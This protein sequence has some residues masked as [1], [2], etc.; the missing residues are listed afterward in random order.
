M[1]I[2]Q[3]ALITIIIGVSFISINLLID[4]RELSGNFTSCEIRQI[5]IGMT[6]EQVQQTLGQPFQIT[7]LAGLHNSDCTRQKSR[8]IKDI[9]E[10]SDI[11]EI[12]NQKFSETDYCCEGNREDLLNK[13]VTLVYTRPIEFSKHYP[14]LWVHLDSNFTVVNVFA[15]QYDGFLGLEDPCIYSLDQEKKFENKKLFEKNFK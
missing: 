6:L 14:M 7:S 12:I 13:R 4:K 15:K 9:S 5:K 3:I 2:K 10:D 1:R 11:R 8:L